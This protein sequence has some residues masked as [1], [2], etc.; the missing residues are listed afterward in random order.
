MTSYLNVLRVAGGRLPRRGWKINKFAIAR[1][2]GFGRHVL[3]SFPSVAAILAAFE[4]AERIQNNSDTMDPIAALQHYLGRLR[5]ARESLPRSKR[6]R[7]NKL[8]IARACRFDRDVF[9]RNPEALALL[10]GNDALDVSRALKCV[11]VA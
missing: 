10:E 8:A 9:Y 3:V 6:G 1:A 7:P 2:C 5:D 11:S 4:E